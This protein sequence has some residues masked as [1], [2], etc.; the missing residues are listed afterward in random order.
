MAFGTADPDAPVTRAD[1]ERALRHANLADLELRDAV[2]QLG[3]RLLALTDELVRRVDGVEPEPAPPNTAARAPTETIEAAL[4]ETVPV[5]L[6]RVRVADANQPSRVVLDLGADKYEVEPTTPPCDEVLHLCQARCCKLTFALSTRDLDEGVIRWDYGQPYLIRQR[7]SDGY[8]VHND[9]S[10]RGCTVH[11]FRPRVCRRYDCRNDAR[12]W[13]DFEKRIPAPIEN[14]FDNKVESSST[15][16]L[17][18]RAQ[19]RTNAIAAEKAAIGD[20]FSQ[21]G[22]EPGPPANPNVRLKPRDA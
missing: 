6:E 12:V 18:E 16:D 20:T 11:A 9:P 22:P 13:I 2:L 4:A 3:A 8:C 5:V 19:K 1:L 7:E 14:M 10:S 21:R 17:V 15:F